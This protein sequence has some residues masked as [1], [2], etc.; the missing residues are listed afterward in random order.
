MFKYFLSYVFTILTT[1]ISGQILSRDPTQIVSPSGIMKIIK[2][3]ISVEGT[4]M[5]FENWENVNLYLPSN[6]VVQNVLSNYDV[7]N[8]FILIKIE[9]REWM[10]DPNILD[11]LVVI[12][13]QRTFV[14]PA[15]FNILGEQ[16]LEILHNTNN[17]LLLKKIRVRVLKPNYN[18]LMDVGSKNYKIEQTNLYIIYHKSDGRIIET[19]GKK[20][21]FKG[22]QK[23]KEINDFIR[24]NK[25]KLTDE[26]DLLKFINYYNQTMF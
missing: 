24:N 1:S 12:L 3:P 13:T 22:L 26:L 25:L 11:S 2:Y 4:E 19:I 20:K 9:D 16:L 23:Y 10:L 18:E 17:L 21:D 7:Y 8:N 14:N 5:L 6:K 15:L